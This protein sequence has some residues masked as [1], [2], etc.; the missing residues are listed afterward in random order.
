MSIPCKINP[1]GWVKDTGGLPAGYTQL[2]YL[3]SS[4]SQYIQT[5][6]LPS[7]DSVIIIDCQFLQL[8]S[9]YVYA[10]RGT[11]VVWAVGDTFFWGGSGGF[12]PDNFPSFLNRF[13]IENK[14]DL[15]GLILNGELFLGTANSE[16]PPS[17]VFSDKLTLFAAAYLNNFCSARVFSFKVADVGK[18]LLFV[19]CLDPT[20]APCMFDMV[21]RQPFYNA[22]SGDFTYA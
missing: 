7:L 4:G 21:S 8:N 11:G 2:E 3:E 5:D 18:N 12:L 10:S 22:G 19:P 20:G 6:I 1:L 17:G 15:G 14:K 9:R 13:T 16:G